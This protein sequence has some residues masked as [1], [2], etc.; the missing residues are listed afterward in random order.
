[1][2]T[3]QIEGHIF[4]MVDA[5]AV[6][7]K[8]KALDYYYDLLALKEPPMRILYMLTEAVPVTSGGTVTDAAGHGTEAGCF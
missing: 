6:G 8:K 1:M 2:C 5:V 3:A 7:D 4:E